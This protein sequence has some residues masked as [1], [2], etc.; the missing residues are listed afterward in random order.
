[1][2]CLPFR[3]ISFSI[4]PS[5]IT[6]GKT[7]LAGARVIPDKILKIWSVETLLNNSFKISDP[8]FGNS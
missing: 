3:I 5:L 7:K 2:T 4:L 6:E 1:M 8:I